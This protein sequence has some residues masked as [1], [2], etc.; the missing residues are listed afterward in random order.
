MSDP[1]IVRPPVDG[2]AGA[3]F[4]TRAG[5]VS[6]GPF[7]ACNV[8]WGQGDAAAAVLANRRAVCAALG[9]DPARVSV[10][11]QVHGTVVRAVAAPEAPG[12]FGAALD[13]WPEGDGLTT[14]T[15]GAGLAVLGADCLPILLWRRDVPRV[16]AVHSG[17]RGL[18][19]GIVENAVAALGDPSRTGAAIG[20]GVGPC[21]YEVGD[22]VRAR[23]AA[24]FGPSPVRGRH[25]D[26]ADAARA[27]LTGAGLPASAVW[28][29][30]TCTRCDGDRWFSYRR[31]GAATGRQAG[32]VWP[33]VSASGA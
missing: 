32:I 4:T 8:G 1:V 7:A 16:A 30:D 14:A 12:G 27:A 33:A 17:W 9:L 26:L 13:G 19:F 31:D 15:P 6:T 11:R 21:C 24:R 5:G 10:G 20:P 23:Y 3:A 25:L 29:L 28:V 22:D 18:A 2:P